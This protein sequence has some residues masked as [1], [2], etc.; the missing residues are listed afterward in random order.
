MKTIKTPIIPIKKTIAKVPGDHE[1]N[2]EGIC[3][4]I[5]FGFFFDTDSYWKDEMI[6]SPG[7][8]YKLDKDNNVVPSENINGVPGMFRNW[9]IDSKIEIVTSFLSIDHQVIR[10]KSD[11]SLPLVFETMI[12]DHTTAEHENG[13]SKYAAVDRYQKRYGTYKEATAGHYTAVRAIRKRYGN[14]NED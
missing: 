10:L 6:L 7:S 4:F 5:A 12:F 13:E 9:E 3:I 14:E 11:A 8:E 2:L 1:L